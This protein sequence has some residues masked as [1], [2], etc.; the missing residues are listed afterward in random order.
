MARKGT[1]H[2]KTAALEAI[3]SHNSGAT[4]HEKQTARKLLANLK[5]APADTL[6]ELR[7]EETDDVWTGQPVLTRNRNGANAMLRGQALA[8]FLANIRD[9]QEITYKSVP[10]AD[11]YGSGDFYVIL[12]WLLKT[13]HAHKLG[14][15]YKIPS[16]KAIKAAWNDQIEQMKMK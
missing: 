14:S 6:P 16:I 15:R 9:G 2:S 12:S 1:V 13:G 10:F 4:P 7:S 3:A 8:H 11:N 5:T